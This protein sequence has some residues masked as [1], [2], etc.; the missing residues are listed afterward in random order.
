MAEVIQKNV[1]NLKEPHAK[2][3]EFLASDKKRIVLNWG[4]RT[5]KSFGA[6]VKVAMSA[7]LEQGN[8]YI[9][10]PTIGNAE[11]IYWD[12]VLKVIF[13]NSPLVDKQFVKDIGR[14]DWNEVGFN[15]NE[16]SITIDYIENAKV[17][18]PDGR[19]V[20][21]NHDTSQ[22]RSK[23]VLYGA[24]EPDNIL[25]IG[26]RGVVMDECAKMNNFN[27]VWRKVIRPMLGDQQ[28]W[29]VFISTPL[30][31]H[32]PWYEWVN[33]AKSDPQKYFFSHATAYDNHIGAWRFPVEEIE[34]AKQD[35]IASGELHVFEQEWLAEFVNPEGAIFPEFDLEKHTFLPSEL[36]KDGVHVAGIDFGFSPD[37]AAILYC[38]IDEQGNWWIYDE[39]YDTHLD[40]DRIANVLKNKMM[41]TT[42][43]R[44][45]AD[46]QRKD[47][48]ELL[49]RVYR[50]PVQPGPKG[51]GSIK[52]GIAQIHAM[53]RIQKNGQPRLK[54]GR[55]LLNTIREFQS[56]S[57]KRDA[58]G[59]YFDQPEDTNNHTI[60]A[61]RYI[62][63]RMQR[64]DDNP[65]SSKSKPKAPG[66][67]YSPVTGRPLN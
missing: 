17:T 52:T 13:K 55:H 8:Y 14:K 61:L 22:P 45:V 33:L 41:D 15:E 42:F 46:A 48:I 12:D 67:R 11:K 23:I 5:G 18:M 59:T 36:P 34:E 51:S 26:I 60:D 30:G 49:R 21:V 37:P 29:A 10:A 43:T 20:T 56:Y 54:I 35:A 4:R 9:I 40:D 25:G 53:L 44:I 62:L 32:N 47:S 38:L 57:R 66:K 16:K 24:T 63:G 1:L 39:T 50:V 19:V 27:Y 6:G 7:I 3:K 28:G 58:Q 65:Y 2:Q 31:I 64:A